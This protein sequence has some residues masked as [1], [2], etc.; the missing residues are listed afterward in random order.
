MRIKKLPDSFYDLLK[1]LNSSHLYGGAMKMIHRYWCPRLEGIGL[2]PEDCTLCS[3][4]LLECARG[5]KERNAKM[6]IPVF[7]AFLKAKAAF[8]TKHSS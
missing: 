7:G 5:A 4:N 2:C 8:F 3:D 6:F 1:T